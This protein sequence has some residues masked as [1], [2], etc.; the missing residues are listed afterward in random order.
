MDLIVRLEIIVW[1]VLAGLLLIT[2]LI[3]LINAYTQQIKQTR[4]ELKTNI[5]DFLHQAKEAAEVDTPP[6]DIKNNKQ[7]HASPPADERKVL[8][9]QQ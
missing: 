7:A 2:P 1:I 4:Q 3:W 5:T 9:Q 8:W 6:S